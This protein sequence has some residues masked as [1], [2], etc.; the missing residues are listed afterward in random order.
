MRLNIPCSSYSSSSS[1]SWQHSSK[2]S[3]TPPTSSLHQLVRHSWGHAL[4]WCLNTSQKL[5]CLIYICWTAKTDCRQDHHA[6]DCDNPLFLIQLCP[7]SAMFVIPSSLHQ[8]VPL[9][10]LTAL[11]K[12]NLFWL[13]NTSSCSVFQQNAELSKCLLRISQNT[14]HIETSIQAEKDVP[15]YS[16]QVCVYQYSESC[17]DPWAKIFMS[18]KTCPVYIEKWDKLKS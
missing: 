5:I 3:T 9:F 12:C 6:P 17:P 8:A 10:C 1:L 16:L 18:L 14:R 15:K 13:S 4:S 7:H 11:W 2:A